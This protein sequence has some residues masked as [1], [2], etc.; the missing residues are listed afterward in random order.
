MPLTSILNMKN[1]L[2]ALAL[3]FIALTGISQYSLTVE[4]APAVTA[5]FTTYRVYV[6][7]DHANDQVSAIFGNN[8]SPLSIDVPDG[9]FNSSYNATWNASGINPSFLPVFPELADDTYATIGLEGPAS[10]SG[11]EGASD[12][13]IVQDASQEIVPFFTDSASTSLLANTI[14]GSSWYVLSTAENAFAGADMRVLILQVTT[15]GEISGTINYQV[16]DQFVVP[17]AVDVQLTTS[18]SG[19]GTF[20]PS[21]TSWIEGCTDEAACN[22][23]DEADED[24]GSCLYDDA[25]GICGGD[26]AAD[27][28]ADGICDDEDACVGVLD[29]CGVCNGPG[30]IYE[31]GCSDIPTGDCDCDGNQ[32]DAVGV[33][34]GGCTADADADGVCDDEDD[35]VGTY[36]TCGVCNGPGEIYECGCSDI[37][38]GECDCNGN[39]LD[40]LGVCG[41][42]CIADDNE[43]GICDNEEVGGCTDE[44]ACNYDSEANYDDGSCAYAM[45]ACDDGDDMTIDDMYDA[46]CMCVGIDAVPGCTDEAACNYDAEAGANTDDG[47]C[48]YEDVLGECGGDCTAD[49]DD[50]GIC[51]DEDDCVGAVSYTHLTLP[52]TPYV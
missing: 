40:A 10:T 43:N 19:A 51:D 33:C 29:A 1:F 48:L 16:F 49:A 32:L 20:E 3:G 5:G 18:F 12:P 14:I 39:Q 37:P 30:E 7:C 35:C 17:P 25:L 21:S 34:G 2:L 38:A 28:D 45:D 23:D 13:D 27:E 22:Y 15:T 44:D 31:C 24:D 9:A 6:N 46:D 42:E 26:C 8:E 47:S 41:G 50:D 11:I 52:T 4:S 36:D